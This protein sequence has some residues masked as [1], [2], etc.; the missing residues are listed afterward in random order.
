MPSESE[1]EAVIDRFI[2]AVEQSLD[3]RAK[4]NFRMPERMCLRM[5]LR[6]CGLTGYP[7][8]VGDPHGERCSGEMVCEQC[9]K[10]Y[11][12]H[13]ADWRVIGYGDVPF[14]NVLCNGQRVKL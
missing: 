4:E 8:L 7:D 10:L 14:L 11:Y 1:H 9:G 6:A 5:S 3:P 2:N 13:P 12:A